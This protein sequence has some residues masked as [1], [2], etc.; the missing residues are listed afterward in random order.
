[1]DKWIELIIPSNIIGLSESCYS[2][3][4]FN[5]VEKDL[6]IRFPSGYKDFCRV[7]G[8]GQLN[9]HV[10]IYCPGNAQSRA[11]IRNNIISP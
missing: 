11:H 1:M 5:S 7:L 8:S 3:A 4:V 10:R 6:N 9:D 2:E